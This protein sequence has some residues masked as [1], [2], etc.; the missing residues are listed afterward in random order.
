MARGNA[1]TAA[2]VGRAIISNSVFTNFPSG[3]GVEVVGGNPDPAGPDV[4]FGVPHANV[5]STVV[6][7]PNNRFVGNAASPMQ[8]AVI[9]RFEGKGQG[10]FHVLNHGS[11]TQPVTNI[12]GD[13]IVVDVRGEAFVTAAVTGSYIVANHA[14]DSTEAVGI[15]VTSG[16]FS[17]ASATLEATI[18]NNTI[19]QVDGNGLVAS[20]TEAQASM[21]VRVSGNIVQAPLGLGTATG[22]LV[23]SGSA[24]STDNA[25]CLD[26]FGNTSAGENGG[27]GIGLR[28]EGSAATTNDFGIAGMAVSSTPDVEAFV[29]A[30]NANGGGVSLPSATSGF[31]GCG[32]A[33]GSG[34]ARGVSLGPSE[35][36]IT[37]LR[38]RRVAQAVF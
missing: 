4:V 11:F 8:H 35:G 6:V 29:A 25:V 20:A 26:I 7:V 36:R 27:I 23:R 17:G 10:S 19:A 28:K 31:S 18:A 24:L 34:L 32:A 2:S 38:A 14:V 5:L 3:A 12:A 13:V 21:N 22:I 37:S 9:A 1:S 30:L 15:R 16:E 33:P